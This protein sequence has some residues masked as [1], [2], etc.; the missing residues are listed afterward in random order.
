[1]G[2]IMD[3]QEK[4]L[5]TLAIIAAI[6]M[7]MILLYFIITI[8][9]QHRKTR[10][11]HLEKIQAEIHT[12]ERERKRIANDLHDDLGPM[13]SAIKFKI[14]AVDVVSNSDQKLIESVNEHIDDTLTR[15]RE[16]SFDLMPNALSRKGLIATLEEL[17]PKAQKLF[18]LKIHFSHESLAPLPPEMVIHLYRMILEII[19]NTIKHS[20]ATTLTMKL[21]ITS[22]EV[23]FESADDGIGFDIRTIDEQQQG[24]G[25][26]NLQSRTE[27]MHGELRIETSHGKGVSYQLHIPLT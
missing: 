20:Q 1:M 18:P 14:N 4:T 26:K 16:I 27:I 2:H 3:T 19:H 22:R 17:I 25:L 12:L 8:I 15:I 13:L 5:F 11:L 9:R 24:L 6:V 23:L 7:G 21:F 10:Q